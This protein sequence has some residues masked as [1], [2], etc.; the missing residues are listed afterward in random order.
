MRLLQC[1]PCLSAVFVGC[2][3]V[4]VRLAAGDGRELFSLQPNGQLLST[5]GRLCVSASSEGALA[6]EKCDLAASSSAFEVQGNA[7]LEVRGEGHLCLSQMGSAAGAVD[8]ALHSAAAATSTMDALAHGATMAVDGVASTYW[9]SSFTDAGEIVEFVVD[10][11][12]P[13]SL[14]MADISWEFAAQAFSISVSTDGKRWG[15]VFST[16][17]NVLNRTRVP[18]GPSVATKLKIA[19]SK[20]SPSARVRGRALYGIRSLSISTNALRA[21]V[22]GCGDA[23]KTKDARDK[24]FLS[25]VGEFDPCPSKSMR[26]E[27]PGLEAATSSL[28]AVASELAETISRASVCDGAALSSEVA[29]RAPQAT[30]TAIARRSCAGSLLLGS[31]LDLEAIEHLQAEAKRLILLARAAAV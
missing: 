29:F 8:A 26:G 27:L 16:N 20:P 11:G 14:L 21:V 3:S 28:A 31:E 1:T 24:Y 25:A 12:S 17:V 5:G 10:F 22:G 7:Q 19:M 13:T 2:A 15:D 6:L 4:L 9:A 30:L 23:A 18:L